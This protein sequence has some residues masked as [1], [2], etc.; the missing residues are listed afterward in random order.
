MADLTTVETESPLADV[1]L[2]PSGS[3][4]GVT[5]RVCVG[6][7]RRWIVTPFGCHEAPDRI[8]VPMIRSLDEERFIL[9]DGRPRSEHGWI[10]HV[11]GRVIRALRLEPHLS[12]VLVLPRGFLIARDQEES[13]YPCYSCVHDSEGELLAQYPISFDEATV[14]SKHQVLGATPWSLFLVDLRI[15]PDSPGTEQRAI[16]RDWRFPGLITCPRGLTTV[17]PWV[18]I[19]QDDDIVRW[20]L[21]SGEADCLDRPEGASR[22]LPRG[23]L[24]FLRGR[25]FGVVDLSMAI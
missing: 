25:G 8:S 13:P 2:S 15:A 17:G 16:T 23:R 10:I 3:W 12:E 5:D 11:D 7:W 9:V 20:S 1:D 22:L 19:L 18:F 4:V 14:Y 6:D 24:L 21:R